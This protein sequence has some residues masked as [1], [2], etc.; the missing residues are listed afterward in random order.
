MYQIATLEFNKEQNFN[1]KTGINI[2]EI[3]LSVLNTCMLSAP[4]SA[5]NFLSSR[6]WVVWEIQTPL[7]GFK[8]NLIFIYQFNTTNFMISDLKPNLAKAIHLVGVTETTN[9][10][11]F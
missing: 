2:L 1:L 8:K 9:A 10:L 6:P 4:E 11:N 3:S 5:P 7:N